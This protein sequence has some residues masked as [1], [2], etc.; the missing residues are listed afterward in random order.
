MVKITYNMGMPENC[1]SCPLMDEEFYYC[2][3]KIGSKAWELKGISRFE[4]S[5]PSWCP[6][7]EICAEESPTGAKIY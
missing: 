4:P 7:K 6:L 3:G 2:H 1:Y 5:R